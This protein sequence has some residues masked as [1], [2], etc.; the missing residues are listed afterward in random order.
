MAKKRDISALAFAALKSAVHKVVLERERLGMPVIIWRKGR[1]VRVP[2][3][4]ILAEYKK[5]SWVVGVERS[6]KTVK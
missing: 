2:A 6:G 1:V 4:E 5:K 3:S